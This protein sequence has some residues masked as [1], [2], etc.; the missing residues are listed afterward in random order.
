MLC[1]QLIPS[2]GLLGVWEQ[3]F[4]IHDGQQVEHDHIL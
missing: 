1:A 2:T 3:P 4:A